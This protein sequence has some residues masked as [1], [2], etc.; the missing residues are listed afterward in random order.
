MNFSSSNYYFSALANLAVLAGIIFLAIELRQ[1]S[2]IART[3][4]YRENI[5]ALAEWREILVGDPELSRNFEIYVQGNYLSLDEEYQR[6]VRYLI[7]NLFGIYENA[8]IAR[9][10]NI[11]DEDGWQRFQTGACIHYNLVRESRIFLSF[12]TEVFF[13]YLETNCSREQRGNAI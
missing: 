7:N 13:Q 6:R 12:V 9:Q 11:M 8:F 10:N 2:D 5:Q 3:S 1:N 4:E